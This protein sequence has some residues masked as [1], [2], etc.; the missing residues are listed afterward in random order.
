M[1]WP[2][3]IVVFA[4]DRIEVGRRD[5]AI[6]TAK[7]M[8]GVC[9]RK[10]ANSG[11]CVLDLYTP[12]YG[13][14]A[15]ARYLDDAYGRGRW[16]RR[17]FKFA[18]E[19][20]CRM[21]DYHRFNAFHQEWNNFMKDKNIQYKG[22][23]IEDGSWPGLPDNGPRMYVPGIQYEPDATETEHEVS[24]AEESKALETEKVTPEA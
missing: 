12:Q 15:R 14:N 18:R 3:I 20:L 22:L 10:M 21:L 23:G 9:Q 17:V 8:A 11:K 19:G 13:E 24:E 16:L 2:A 7:R 4:K 6:Q 1:A 5:V